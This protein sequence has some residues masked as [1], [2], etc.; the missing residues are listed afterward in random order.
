MKILVLG[1]SLSFPRK[2]QSLLDVWPQIIHNY[3]INSKVDDMTFWFRAAGGS[4]IRDLIKEVQSLNSYISSVEFDL[5][6]VQVGIVDC[7]PR[8]YPLWLFNLFSI[9]PYAYK[10]KLFMHKHIRFFLKIYSEKLVTES[11][12]SSLVVELFNSL[13]K[14]SKNV[15]FIKI[16]PPGVSLME[17]VP[18]IQK[19][20][21]NYNEI[22]ID[23]IKLKNT[24]N[25]LYLDPYS[26]EFN[27]NDDLLIDGHHLSI[28]GHQKLSG[29]LIRFIY[30]KF[31]DNEG[32][33][34]T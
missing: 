29:E 27:V 16:A 31:R 15:L 17:K 12:W 18:N 26:R 9:I 11:E 21:E 20:I 28:S 4:T 30:E 32:R 10:I 23:Q 7:T 5:T 13:Q 25:F 14:I 6:I 34:V 8:P 24:P 2:G 33:G 22:I 3:F 1:D 19:I